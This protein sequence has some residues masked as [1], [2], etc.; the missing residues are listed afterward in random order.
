MKKPVTR[1]LDGFKSWRTTHPTS[2]NKISTEVRKNSISPN[3]TTENKN[4]ETYFSTSKENFNFKKSYEF[5]RSTKCSMHPQN[6]NEGFTN[7]QKKK[8]NYKN[9]WIVDKILLENLT[10]KI[11]EWWLK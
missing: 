5:L 7:R 2:Q 11:S 9:D 8:Y 3:I 6:N 10:S 4:K 1:N